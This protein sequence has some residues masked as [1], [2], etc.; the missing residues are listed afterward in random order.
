MLALPEALRSP[1]PRPG[2]PAVAE[3]RS[4]LAAT[5]LTE[6]EYDGLIQLS[7]AGGLSISDMMRELLSEAVVARQ[8]RFGRASA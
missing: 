1:A 5:C 3:R 2:R 7:K 8:A 6:R 4:C